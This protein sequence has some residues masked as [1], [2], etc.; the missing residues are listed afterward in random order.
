MKKPNKQ[1]RTLRHI[2]N[3]W[4]AE[5]KID[6]LI[7]YK[8]KFKQLKDLEYKGHKLSEDYCNG[9]IESDDW[10]D[11]IKPIK[12]AVRKLLPHLESARA[13]VF[14]NDP[15]G[16][17]LKIDDEYVRKFQLSIYRDFGGYGIIAPEEC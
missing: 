11:K 17:F 6:E 14:N 9:L 8:S 4:I 10:E 15:R 1:E 3:L 7:S 13:L 12:N 2:N 16:Y 5:G